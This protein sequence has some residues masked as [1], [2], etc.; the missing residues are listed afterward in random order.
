MTDDYRKQGTRGPCQDAQ[1]QA[2][3]K[4]DCDNAQCGPGL[5]EMQCHEE[6]RGD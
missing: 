3:T 6:E 1:H 5:V 2:R 4:Y